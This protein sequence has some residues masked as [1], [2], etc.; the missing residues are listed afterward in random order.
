MSSIKKNFLYS[1]FLTTANY[2]F[3]LITFPYVSRVLGATNFGLCNFIDGIID[4]FVLF[5]MMGI[6]L[7]GIREVASNKTS[8]KISNTFFNLL[9]LTFISTAIAF[10]I[11]VFAIIFVP[12]L[13]ANKE[14]MIIGG[15]KLFFNFLLVEWFYKG[16]E[17]F[18][19]ITIR[20]II[21]RSLYVAAVFIFVKSSSDYVIYYFL[22][23]SMIVVNA[24][25]NIVHIRKYVSLSGIKICLR[26]Y[27]KPFITLGV[28]LILTSMYTTFNVA[29]LGFVGGDTQVGYYTTATK[30]YNV[31]LAV[32]AAFTGVM[33]PRMSALITEGKMTEF[34]SKI[35]KSM[36]FLFSVSIPLI[37]YVIMQASQVVLLVAGKGYEGA[38]LPMQIVMP[39]ILIIGYEQILVVQM[40]MPL[41]SDRI[42]LINSVIGAFLGLTLN[43]LLVPVFRSVGSS[44]VWVVCEV[45]ILILSQHAVTKVAGFKFPFKLLFK[46]IICFVP[47]P[48]LIIV[49]NIIFDNYI[50]QL[51]VSGV[52]MIAYTIVIHSL[53]FRDGVCYKFVNSKIR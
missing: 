5:S 53:F 14:L 42:I 30:L 6:G 37:I 29:Y 24:I 32:Y 19:Y 11:L 48:I 46:N 35:K 49:S 31:L 26:K 10:G 20:S 18:K 7:F 33:M 51:L 28:Y 39:L 9:I 45:L 41:K 12:E 50:I 34:Q 25:I 2:V 44:M 15:C 22:I 4:Y 17:D 13:N 52:V 47:L 38:V 1:C 3:P 36:E 27:V 21:V 40:L 43:I 8:E 16:I 23:V